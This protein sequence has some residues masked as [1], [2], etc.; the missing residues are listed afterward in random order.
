MASR[1]AR[2]RVRLSDLRDIMVNYTEEELDDEFGMLPGELWG[3]ETDEEVLSCRTADR[4]VFEAVMNGELME[5]VWRLRVD[6]AVRR[7]AEKLL[8]TVLSCPRYAQSRRG[9]GGK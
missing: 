3:G 6:I 8:L 2:R 9:G 5:G 7:D 4:N 1:R